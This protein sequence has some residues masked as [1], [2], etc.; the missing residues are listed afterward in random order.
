MDVGFENAGITISV[1]NEID[2][3]CSGNISSKSHKS[4]YANWRH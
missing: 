4:K 3:I 2:Q 1:A